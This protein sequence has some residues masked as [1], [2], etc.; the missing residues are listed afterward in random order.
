MMLEIRLPRIPVREK[1]DVLF[2]KYYSI[3]FRYRGVSELSQLGG[4]LPSVMDFVKP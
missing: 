2:I 1:Y 4:T 3:R